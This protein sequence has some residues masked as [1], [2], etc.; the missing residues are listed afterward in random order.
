MTNQRLKMP[1]FHMVALVAG[2]AALAT[3]I[4]VLVE[5]ETVAPE[6][7]ERPAQ[8]V[9]AQKGH[10]VEP[11]ST[12]ALEFVFGT[13]GFDLKQVR[14]GSE[15]VP[16]IYVSSLPDDLGFIDEVGRKKK[17]FFSAV[18]P[19]VLSANER[20][21]RDRAKLVRL[22][23]RVLDGANLHSSEKDWL[24]RLA[25]RYGVESSGDIDR[26]LLNALNRRVDVVPVSLA[27]AQ[28]AVESG[29][30]SSRFARHGNALFGQRAWSDDKG[31]VPT[32]RTDSEGHVVRKY[33]TLL[34]SVS[35][36]IHNLNTH[37]SYS[38]FRSYREEMR[39][40]G[41]RLDGKRLAGGLLAYAEIGEEYVD[42]LRRVIEKNRLNELDDALLNRNIVTAFNQAG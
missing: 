35:S 23:D 33:D 27:L 37:P 18:L 21:S 40:S 24:L 29:W 41:E 14:R 32:E 31:I 30:G 34:S 17:L 6:R 8:T 12:K 25:D 3:Q 10:V 38:D 20:V 13:V 15:P 7:T 16:A 22:R 9:S 19:L 1:S 42:I 4:S 28:A 2:A 36:Y 11:A 5:P 39:E 26:P